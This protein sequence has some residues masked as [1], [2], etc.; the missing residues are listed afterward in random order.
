MPQLNLDDI[1]SDFK[2]TTKSKAAPAALNID[3][4]LSDFKSSSTAEPKALPKDIKKVIINTDPK[5][6][7]SGISKE[8]SDELNA[9]RA[10]K[11]LPTSNKFASPDT[12]T[13]PGAYEH[14]LRGKEWVSD[15]I[16]DMGSGHPYKGLGKTVLGSLLVAGAPVSGLVED[17]IIK[18]GNKIEPGFG[19]RAGL[20]ANFALPV[21]PGASGISALASG[22]PIVKKLSNHV[23][24][25]SL[26]QLVEDIGEKNLPEAVARLKENPRLAPA[27]LSPKVLQSTQELFANGGSHVN[28][29]SE[30]SAKRMAGAKEAVE[31]AYDEA[32]GMAVNA[33]DKLKELKQAASDIGSK[34]ISPAIANA[35]FVD[36]GPVL[37]HIDE[38]VSPGVTS[39]LSNDSTL[40]SL[41][42]VDQLNKVRNLLANAE[43]QRVDANSLHT[44]QTILRGTAD[45]LLNSS[46]GQ[47][48]LMGK[49][50]M[51]VRNE[52]VT[53][54]DKAA[55][56]KYKPALSNYRDAK[57]IDDAFQEGYSSVF[58]NSKK[59]EGRPEFT[60][61]WFDGLS[62][63]EKSA[64]REGARLQLDT[65]INNVRFAAKRGRDIPEV[66]FN[67][68]KMEMLFGKEE[69]NKLLKTV[70]DESTIAN[71]HN[72]VIEGSQT[73]M[74]DS[75][76]STWKM[77]EKKD[78]ANNLVAG[79]VMETGNIMAHGTPG[80]GS[81][82]LVGAQIVN[83]VAHRAKSAVHNERQAQYARYALPT[84]GPSRD[85]LIK[86]LEARIS[87]PKPSILNRARMLVA[88]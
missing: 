84:E 19:D 65:Q 2:G 50:L 14:H 4:I 77:P 24:N 54:I 38:A 31:T 73:A 70:R 42:I 37:K 81:A 48:K 67:R 58:T 39:K 75:S 32:T 66:D 27:D 21:V 78:M 12:Y 44:V 47:D 52:L 68:Q 83:S 76:K 56:G 69:T 23:K 45:T 29:L 72:K 15:G 53:S 59:I 26:S 79:A 8:A 46:N 87:V 25:K 35:K 82:M 28:Y 62:D 16:N 86:Q 30:T 64:A 9:T 71:T 1:L 41:P 80:V 7:I 85:E 3:A 6:P 5:P 22:I 20:V 13:S 11:G 10:E 55:G 51:N 36:V 74:R 33:V 63:A 60:K 40:T 88:P 34:E 57:H 18:P 49:A 43:A 61:E 17:L